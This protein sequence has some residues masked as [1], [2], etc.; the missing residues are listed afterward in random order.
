MK[1]NFHNK[2][3]GAALVVGLIV[4]LIM[5]ILGVASMS[6]TTTELKIANNLQTKNF[7]FQAA[8]TA[9]VAISDTTSAV[10]AIKAIDWGSDNPSPPLPDIVTTTVASGTASASA[11]IR[12]VGCMNTPI[13]FEISSGDQEGGSSAYKALVHDIDVNATVTSGIR[14]VGQ[15][16]TVTGVQTVRP[17]CPVVP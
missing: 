3:Q 16:H 13:N 4:L 1:S 8:E 6:A 11:N 7:A 2:Q 5:T 17:G 9:T 10:A 12:Y 14:T 15:A